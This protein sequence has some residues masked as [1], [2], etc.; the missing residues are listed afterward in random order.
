MIHPL[1]SRHRWMIFLLAG[2][3]PILFIAAL[4][5]RGPLPPENAEIP[6]PPA[7]ALAF[8]EPISQQT[9][10][11]SHPGLSYQLFSKDN[12]ANDRHNNQNNRAIRLTAA[13]TVRLPT[14]LIYWSPD[15]TVSNGRLMGSWAVSTPGWFAIP[16]IASPA[17]GWI[18]LYDLAK[19][20]SVA[21]IQ[22]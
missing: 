12:Q 8:T 14:L 2:I 5:L 16:E 17:S 1:R 18:V 6:D 20:E 21:A 22:L 19:R 13:E 10:I 9:A 3:V 7:D 15:Q 11:A 4:L